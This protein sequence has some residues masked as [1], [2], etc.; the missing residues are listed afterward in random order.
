MSNEQAESFYQK[1]INGLRQNVLDNPTD[2]ET[3]KS[4]GILLHLYQRN[5]IEA[6]KNYNELLKTDHND[7]WIM[8]KLAQIYLIESNKIQGKE[9]IDNVFFSDTKDYD[10]KL[11]L[12]F[13]RFVHFP[14]NYPQAKAKIM[15]LLESGAR[16][17]DS[18]FSDNIVQ[19]EKDGHPNIALLQALAD[20]ITGKAEL[21]SLGNAT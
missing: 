9:L 7:N 11:E 5:Y 12:W 18:G 3:L 4:L 8:A 1:A 16:S 15:A 19:A 6:K 10:L 20:V 21:E 17:E 13:Y 2:T 14:Q